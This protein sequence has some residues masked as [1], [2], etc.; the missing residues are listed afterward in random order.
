MTE[1]EESFRE[2]FLDLGTQYYAAARESARV[3][4]TPVYGNLF[5]HALEMYLKAALVSLV[6]I[7]ELKNKYK[8]NLRRLWDRLKVDKP[9]LGEFDGV[10][11]DI[12]PFE[13]IRYPD[14]IVESGFICSI[15]WERE[16]GFSPPHITVGEDPVGRPPYQLPR[17]YQPVI[18][19]IDRL[20]TEV[21][22]RIK[23]NPKYLLKQHSPKATPWILYRN[24]DAIRWENAT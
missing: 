24:K 8:H 1:K 17:H 11:A 18:A 23:V 5:H 14:R 2:V 15:N 12:D 4:L 19:E 21:L 10:I 13:D 7:D 20:V 3:G 9:D 22:G 6:P 16:P